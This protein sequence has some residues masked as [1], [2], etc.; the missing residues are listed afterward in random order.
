MKDIITEAQMIEIARRQI[1]ETGHNKW[2]AKHNVNP[3]EV[4]YA[5]GGKV[6]NR[7]PITAAVAHA[8]GYRR[9]EVYVP[10]EQEAR[11]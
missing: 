7:R 1:V 8:L 10:I 4:T 11:R 5:A 3:T 2:A 6:V 9:V